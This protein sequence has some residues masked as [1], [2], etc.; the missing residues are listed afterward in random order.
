MVEGER[1]WGNLGILG[2]GKEAER[3]VGLVCGWVCLW[4][5]G[6]GV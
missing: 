6:F 5:W 4:I 3:G 2:F 1:G